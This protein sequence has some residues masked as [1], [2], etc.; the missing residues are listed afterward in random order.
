MEIE[1]PPIPLD[2]IPVF[3]EQ[4]VVVNGK[5]LDDY[6]AINRGDITVAVVSKEYS[7]IQHSKVIERLNQVVKPD[8]IAKARIFYENNGAKMY[9][10]LYYQKFSFKPKVND[11]VQLGIRICNSVDG[12]MKLMIVPTSYRLA[13]SNGVTHAREMGMIQR[14]HLGDALSV[15]TKLEEVIGEV[16]QRFETIQT[17][18]SDWANTPI[19]FADAV[20]ILEQKLP[21][22][23]VKAIKLA[24]PETAWDLFNCLTQLNTHDDRRNDG[25]KMDFD[26]TIEQIMTVQH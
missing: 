24:K 8:E 4:D 23:Y 16:Q 15:L 11:E 12:S 18:Y 9:L 14:K 5:V 13:C 21:E 22:K 7:L 1:R 10:D 3:D 2:R 17:R 20:P 25:L 6:K 26:R 19:V